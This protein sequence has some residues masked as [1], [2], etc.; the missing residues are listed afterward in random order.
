MTTAKPN[1]HSFALSPQNA[2][3]LLDISIDTLDRL[4]HDPE[5]GWIQG[6]HWNK[7]PRGGIRY[8]A[9]LLKDWFAN[10]HDLTTHQR[11]IEAWRASLLSSKRKRG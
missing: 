6:V 5:S 8:N 2:A 7:L 11:A 4:R 1:S 9:E 3:A 10:V